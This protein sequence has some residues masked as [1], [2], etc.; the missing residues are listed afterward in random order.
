MV[1]GG[2]RIGQ[3]MGTGRG[4]L[5]GGGV[6]VALVWLTLLLTGCAGPASRDGADTASSGPAPEPVALPQ[7]GAD[8]PE[9]V[10]SA[11]DNMRHDAFPEP[12]V[13]PDE[14]ISG[15]PPPDGIPPIDEPTFL[16]ADDVDF[17][18]DTEAILA[19]TIGSET[20]GYPVQIMTYHE[21]VNDTVGDVPVAVTYCPLCN[22][23]LAF[24][25]QVG[26]R[27]LSF[28]TSGR[29]WSNNLVMYDRQTQSLWPQMSFTASVGIL[30]GTELV[31]HLTR[32][33]AWDE[34]RQAH[35]DAWVLSRDTGY[36]RPYGRNPYLGYDQPDSR[37]LFGAPD[38]DRLAPQ[39]R[40][41]GIEDETG[42]GTPVALVELTVGGTD[43]VA[44]HRPGQAS[45]LETDEVAG[46]RDIGTVGV[47]VPELDGER[48][49]FTADGAG[50]RDTRTG[51]TWNVL[52]LATTGPLSGGQLPSYRHVDTFWHSWVAFQPETTIVR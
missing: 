6:A 34:F 48:L 12:L 52:G 33:L 8:P 29:L 23:G 50:F 46:G 16:K 18:T 35:P 1:R 22:S 40:V 7:A 5:R 28:G 11:L 31:P 3:V 25:R 51:S 24:E 15:G 47:Y 45:A 32:L 14:I 41:I 26:D 19:L 38:D 4:R 9:D 36:D 10:P 27:L 49:T 17:L 42:A 43:L 20:R 13:D 39:V 2:D 37:P 21:I 30:T 44:W